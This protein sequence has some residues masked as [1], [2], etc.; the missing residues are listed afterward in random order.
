ML[1]LIIVDDE[2][3]MRIGL[4]SM[5]QWEE[6]G[7]EIAGEASN[8]KEA[9]ELAEK[10]APDLIITDVRM[11]VMDGLELIRETGKVLPKCTYVILSNFDEF[12]YVKEAMQLG[13]SD[14][15]IKCEIKQD[16][17]VQLLGRIRQQ[18]SDR[19][20]PQSGGQLPDA[21][22]RQSL[23]YLKE[24][25]F[26][27]AISGLQSEQDIA[28]KAGPLN[29]RLRPEEM[30]MLKLKIEQFDELKKKYVEQDEKLL[31]FSIVNIL[32]EVIPG[33]WSRE[34]VVESSS[35]YLL[36]MNT[37]SK[38]AD[39]RSDI[40]KL[41]GK[42]IRSLKDFMNVQLTVG[43]STIVR[44]YRYIKLA[45]QEATLALQQR[46][47]AG[48]GRV[49]FF[50]EMERYPAQASRG[51]VL[52]RKQEQEYQL[53]IEGKS[54]QRLQTFLEDIRLELAQE[55]EEDIRS[56]Y[57]SLIEYANSYFTTTLRSRYLADDKSLYETI[58]EEG[59]WDEIHQLVHRYIMGLFESEHKNGDQQTYANMAIRIM[60]RY[61]NADISL[62]SVAKQINVNPSYLSRIFKQ[63]TGTNFVNYLIGVRISKAKLLLENKQLKVYEIA[64]QVGYHN[65]SY[66]SRMF[67]KV[68]GVSP[69]EYRN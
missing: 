58:L 18:L 25:L 35:E 31:R 8:G 45:Y 64:E 14:Y 54:V 62:Q 48:A 65:Y 3:L 47:Y 34:I 32:E 42:I 66:F 1:R 69:E 7:F 23:A 46:F 22:Y 16:S 40:E 13:A 39:A 21:D 15:L 59:T 9:L 68:V 12:R 17:L 41:C 57:V 52:S 37:S 6:H 44:G 36:L 20:Q 67:R 56:I 63:E 27:E 30:F 60:D 38:G 33:R 26:K 29:I 2:L 61:Y 10:V 43:V 4:R 55:S 49:L 11:P 50:D 5:I 24:A 51:L 19:I 53:I 28:A